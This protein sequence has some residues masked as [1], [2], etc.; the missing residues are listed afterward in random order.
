MV[1]GIAFAHHLRRRPCSPEGSSAQTLD[2]DQSRV[3]RES[4]SRVWGS[5]GGSR[6]NRF[7]T[8]RLRG[9]Y[10]HGVTRR[11]RRPAPPGPTHTLLDRVLQRRSPISPTPVIEGTG[12]HFNANVIQGDLE[13]GPPTASGLQG[14]IRRCGADR[15]PP[16][17]H[18]PGMRP[19]DHPAPRPASR[20]P[21]KEGS[22]VGGDARRSDRAAVFCPAPAPEPS[23]TELLNE[24]VGT[25]R[26]PPPSPHGAAADR[27]YPPLLRA[28]H[29]TTTPAGRPLV[30]RRACQLRQAA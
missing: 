11:F 16:S 8:R 26:A 20:S 1:G 13:H 28:P 29:P 24:D 7:G 15:P 6:S 12:Q 5:S 22:R 19:E 4:R 14:E 18:R 17:P 25:Q 27:R 23:P 21:L 10:E 9:H 2:R 3:G 30:R